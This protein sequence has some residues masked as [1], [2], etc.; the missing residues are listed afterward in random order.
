MRGRPSPSASTPRS[1]VCTG[2]P[3][4]SEPFGRYAWTYP[5]SVATISSSPFWP[6]RFANTGLA[7]RRARDD[8]RVAGAPGRDRRARTPASA[9]RPSSR[10]LAPPCAVTT[11]RSRTLKRSSSGRPVVGSTGA[12]V[13]VIGQ[14]GRDLCAGR[15]CASTPSI[16]LCSPASAVTTCHASVAG[17]SGGC[18]PGRPLEPV[19]VRRRVRRGDVALHLDEAAAPAARRT[20]AAT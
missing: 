20:T 8:A 17:Y 9:T 16:G 18:R 4:I 3:G 12:P 19:V 2:Q 7:R 6:S 11:T 10:S 5:S 14:R 13:P 15:D 1:R